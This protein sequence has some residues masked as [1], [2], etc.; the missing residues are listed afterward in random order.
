MCEKMLAAWFTVEVR[1][2]S[3]LPACYGL[4]DA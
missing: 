2:V 3:S 4:D 1:S